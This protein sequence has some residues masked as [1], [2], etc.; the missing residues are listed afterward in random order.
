MA[1]NVVFAPEARAD[2]IE[3]YDDLAARGGP[4]RAPTFTERI[5]AMWRGLALFPARGTRRDDI[6]PGCG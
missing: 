4:P 1:H 2:L 3:L 6:R 5:V